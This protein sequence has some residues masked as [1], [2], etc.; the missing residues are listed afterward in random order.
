MQQTPENNILLG[1][2]RWETMRDTIYDFFSDENINP[3]D[4]LLF[5]FSGHGVPD[6]DQDVFLA[7][8]DIDPDVPSKRGFNFNE[9]TK[10]I[11]D[12]ISTSIVAILDCC[13]SGSARISKGREDDAARLGHS[14][15]ERQSEK[16]VLR[17][18][19]KCILAASQAQGE[20]YVLEEHNHSVFTYYLLEALRG[21]VLEAIDNNG[22]LTV[23]SLSKYVYNALM[24]LP[25]S[26][27]PKQKP[28]RKIEAS[29]DIVLAYYPK[30]VT[31]Y[32]PVPGEDIKSIIDRCQQYFNKG[33][34]EQELNYLQEVINRYPNNSDFWNYRGV[35]LDKLNRREEAISCFDIAIMLNPKS[36]NLWMNKGDCL[37]K[38]GRIEESI[39]SF[40]N[41]L[42]LDPN[43][44][45]AW[46]FKAKPLLN[47]RKFD[48]ALDCLN[49]AT[50]KINDKIL[51][52][53]MGVALDELGKHYD[54][55]LTYDKAL[56]ID[57]N[58]DITLNNKGLS[59]YKLGKYQEAI[60]CY[61]RILI[62]NPNVR[63]VLINKYK[64]LDKL[65]KTIEAERCYERSQKLDVDF[66]KSELYDANGKLIS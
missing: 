62:L 13:Y 42:K 30:K 21:K 47:Q 7:T 66:N 58:F 4:T 55:I 33:D 64:A 54:A 48:E 43:N 59:L 14:T 41:A 16:A 34:F 60:N 24:S 17:G 23:D 27:R 3:T 38:Q 25:P 46:Y 9:L 49:K 36:P 44:S 2:V 57:P 51:W 65:G 28:V 8:S 6:D 10:V 22:C 29:G 31:S 53:D 40:D 52:N 61:D 50:Q 39:K 26:K 11:G 1:K 19:G 12:C 15:M 18:E 32:E 5:Y 45:R 37:S 20:A 56:R 63:H 35:A